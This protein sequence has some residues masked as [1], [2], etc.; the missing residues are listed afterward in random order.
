MICTGASHAIKP[1]SC[2]SYNMSSAGICVAAA[3]TPYLGSSSFNLQ[4]TCNSL[5]VLLMVNLQCFNILI[6]YLETPICCSEC[7][8]MH[9]DN[10]RLLVK[11]IRY[12][13]TK[14]R[15]R[16]FTSYNDSVSNDKAAW[17]SHMVFHSVSS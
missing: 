9:G 4:H 16:T 17:Y 5:T 3:S 11:V 2:H 14:L 6:Y 13:R 7:Q 1:N 15:F 10:S 12:V 8:Y